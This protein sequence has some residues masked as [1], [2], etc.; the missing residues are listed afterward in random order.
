[1]S[2]TRRD[3]AA[4][5]N[6]VIVQASPRS[7]RTHISPRCI[8]LQFGYGRNQ[9]K[10]HFAHRKRS[11]R[12]ECV[13]LNETRAKSFGNSVTRMH[14]FGVVLY[15]R[16]SKRSLPSGPRNFES[17]F[18]VFS[19]RGNTKVP[20]FWKGLRRSEWHAITCRAKPFRATPRRVEW[21]RVIDRLT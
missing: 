14:R 19:L 4:G 17:L 6:D 15:P 21:S 1:M 13:Y 2:A 16:E 3:K 18:K 11:H 20:R 9:G 8:P 10:S 5:R 12:A 7:A